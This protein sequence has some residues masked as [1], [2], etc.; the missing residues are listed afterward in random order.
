MKS[1]VGSC[2]GV[3]STAGG[4]FLTSKSFTTRLYEFLFTH[5]SQP[6]NIDLW[7]LYFDLCLKTLT[8]KQSRAS[9]SAVGGWKLVMRK[10][11]VSFSLQCNSY[12]CHV[13]KRGV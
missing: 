8:T 1:C 9:F 4:I 11:E 12:L 2:Y 10:E 13:R 3:P 5:V 6:G 7:D